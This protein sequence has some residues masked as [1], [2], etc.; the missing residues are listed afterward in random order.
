MNNSVVGMMNLP[1]ELIMK[2]WNSLTNIDVLYSFIGVNYSFN[3]LLHDQTYTRSIELT[4]KDMESSLFD[5]IIDRFCLVILPEINQYIECFILEL[6]SM[7][8]I[9]LA[10]DYPCLNKI[11]FTQ[12]SE[13]FI[14]RYFTNNSPLI[15]IFKNN[16]KYLL[17]TINRKQFPSSLTAIDKGKNILLPLFHTFTNLL[18]L[19]FNENDIEYRPFISISGLSSSI[20]SSSTLIN[21]SITIKF[22]DDCLSLLDGRFPNLQKLSVVIEKITNPSLSIENLIK[23]NFQRDITRPNCSKV[24]TLAFTIRSDAEYSHELYSYFPSLEKLF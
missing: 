8:R 4:K 19:D 2:I 22:F 18:E 10:A 16:I 1:D 6:I 7:E 23:K 3:Q 15:K 24:E 17:L 21:L 11:V 14:L 5:S 9:L 12:I 20:C 13:D